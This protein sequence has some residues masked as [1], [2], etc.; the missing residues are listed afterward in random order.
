MPVLSGTIVA[1]A[2]YVLESPIR[3]L[4]KSGNVKRD[5][6]CIS[7]P[8]HAQGEEESFFRHHFGDLPRDQ[9]SADYAEFAD[10]KARLT[11]KHSRC[12]REILALSPH[13]FRSEDVRWPGGIRFDRIVV[14]A[15][16]VQAYFDEMI[17]FWTASAIRACAYHYVATMDETRAPGAREDFFHLP[18]LDTR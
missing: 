1:K 18:D 7:V 8:L 14:G 12:T 4:L 6:V 17:G 5:I 15:S 10:A 16:G 11:L 13:L 2:I 3:A 9:W